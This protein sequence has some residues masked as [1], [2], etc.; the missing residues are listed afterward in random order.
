MADRLFKDLL[1]T[2]LESDLARLNPWWRGLP[3][4]QLP[5][6]RRWAFPVAMRRLRQ[7]LTKVTV[8]RGPRQIGKSTLIRQMIDDLLGQGVPARSILMVQFDE[9]PGLLDVQEPILR[10][11]DWFEKRILDKTF[12]EAAHAGETAY[13]FLDEVQNLD[14]WAPQLKFL[15]DNSDVRV[16]VRRPH[17]GRSKN[18]RNPPGLAADDAVED[19]KDAE[20]T[21]WFILW[22]FTLHASRAT[23]NRPP[24][25]AD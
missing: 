3:Q 9:L 20:G 5:P 18:R 17:H 8:L 19:P 25:N 16:M 22:R 21:G 10:L 12:N 1:S 11:A 7:G 15:V 23:R 4:P 2:T 6:V 13:V 24:M 14:D